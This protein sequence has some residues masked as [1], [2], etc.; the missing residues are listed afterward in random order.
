LLIRVKATNST[1]TAAVV[2]SI[3]LT[4]LSVLSVI[5][6]RQVHCSCPAKQEE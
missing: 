6:S 5:V 3:R 1:T 4:V 2:I